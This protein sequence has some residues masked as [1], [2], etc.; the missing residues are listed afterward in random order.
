MGSISV[1][2]LVPDCYTWESGDRLHKALHE[3]LSAD[4][5][6]VLSFD[7]VEDVPSSFVNAAFVPLVESF[8]LPYVKKHLSVVQS[9]QQINELIKSMLKF[10][11]RK[12]GAQD[13][14]RTAS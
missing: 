10:D 5:R 1:L 13:Q 8:G 4:R 14:P 2:N 12:R 3:H 9:T 6:V 7:G 11:A